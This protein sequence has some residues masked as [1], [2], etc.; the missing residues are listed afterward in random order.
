MQKCA[1]ADIAVSRH[2]LKWHGKRPTTLNYWNWLIRWVK[3]GDKS[4][5]TLK[6]E[7]INKLENITWIIYDHKSEKINGL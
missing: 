7:L 4:A 5:N 3:I 1:I 6:I 2:K